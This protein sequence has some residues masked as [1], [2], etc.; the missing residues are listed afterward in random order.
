MT[1]INLRPVGWGE[2]TPRQW[3]TIRNMIRQVREGARRNG[4]P[5]LLLRA[6]LFLA[7]TEGYDV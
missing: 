1:V 2:M 6:T 5:V 4:D 3:D 7:K